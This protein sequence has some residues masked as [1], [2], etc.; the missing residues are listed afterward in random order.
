[1]SSN[2]H[3][4][5]RFEA[6]VAEVFDPLQRYLRRRVDR[7]RADDVFSD[8][9]LTVWRRLDDVP[10]DAALPWVY[11]VARR[12]L[13]NERRGLARN[14]RLVER[15]AAQPR[16]DVSPDPADDGPDPELTQALAGLSSD[17][18]EI[19]RLWAWEQLEPREIAPVLGLS[20]NATTLRLSRARSRIAEQLGRQDDSP[21][22][23][24]SLQGTPEQT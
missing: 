16:A 5:E 6:I 19:I 14:Q 1:M 18:R 9:L 12:T 24:E 23:H 7:G 15:L 2:N 13:S 4:S 8:V 10:A 22:G 3:R 17:D 20:V 11:G 21:S